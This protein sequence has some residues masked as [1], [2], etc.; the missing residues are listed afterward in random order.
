M[1]VI[2]SFPIGDRK[3][4]SRTLETAKGLYIKAGLT[5]V[6]AEAACSELE[7]LLAPLL[8]EYESVFDLPA[9]LGLS[10]HQ[11]AA[12]TSAHNQCIQALV[13]HFTQQLGYAVSTIAGLVGRNH[14]E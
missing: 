6:Q 14:G 1:A 4:L 3:G 9:A 8:K 7:P 13:T 11:V 12:I 5:T 2:L 10:E